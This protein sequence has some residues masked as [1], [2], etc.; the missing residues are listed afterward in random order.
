VWFW[1]E[2]AKDALTT[3]VIPVCLCTIRTQFAV[4]LTACPPFP[5]PR[6]KDSV[7]VSGV[8]AGSG[9]R[10]GGGAGGGGGA[11]DGVVLRLRIVWRKAVRI[12]DT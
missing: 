9:L 5:D 11:D 8:N 4:L 12:K 7:Y 10:D 3:T 1:G 2:G 6:M